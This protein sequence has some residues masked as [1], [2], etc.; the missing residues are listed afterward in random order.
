M[1]IRDSR[2]IARKN[3][4]EEEYRATLFHCILMAVAKTIY[5]RP[6]LNSFI[7]GRR[8]YQRDEITLGFVAK[9]VYKR[10]VTG[11]PPVPISI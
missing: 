5:L 8:F 3:E 4:G 1:C 2:Y 9:D 10:Q 7:S 11:F 6:Q